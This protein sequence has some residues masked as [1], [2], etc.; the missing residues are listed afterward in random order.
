MFPQ[1]LRDPTQADGIDNRPVYPSPRNTPSMSS[2]DSSS[3]AINNRPIFSSP[4]NT[5]SISSVDSPQPR[6]EPSSSDQDTANRRQNIHHGPR[7]FGT[8][9]FG[10][11]KDSGWEDWTY[12]K[13][14]LSGFPVKLSTWEVHQFVV[15]YGNITSVDVD[16]NNESFVVFW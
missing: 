4:R 2:T 1:Q 9:N 12:V 3:L 15:K 6:S 10:P 13:V 16:N 7:N 8:R 11:R 5:P 14:R